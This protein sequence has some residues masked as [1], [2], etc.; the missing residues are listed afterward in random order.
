MLSDTETNQPRANV[1]EQNEQEL[2]ELRR[3]RNGNGD[4]AHVDHGSIDQPAAKVATKRPFY[5]RPIIASILGIV[6]LVALFVGTQLFLHAMAYESTDDAF[7]EG[8]VVQISTKSAGYA[9][10][11]AVNDN[12]HVKAG[13]LLVQVD[14]RD[15]QAKLDQQRAFVFMAQSKLAET[16]TNL[17]ALRANVKAAESEVASAQASYEHAKIEAEKFAKMDQSA[18]WEERHGA[19]T[20]ALTWQANVQTAQSKLAAAQ[21][22]VANGESQVKTAEAQVA[23]AQTMVRQ[24]ELDVSYTTI[25]APVDGRVTRK[26]VEPGA[27]LSVGQALLAVVPDDV[28]VVANFKETQLK[29]MR[30]GQKVDV[31]IDAYPDR[32]FEGHVDSIQSG[33][34]SRF[35][36]LPPENATGNYVKVVQRVPVKIV[37]DQAPPSDL[38]LAPGMSVEPEVL[39]K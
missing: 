21:A 29:Q 19:E 20:E 3:R 36:L 32:K 39:V 10:Q 11:V 6:A 17:E 7:I 22:Q 34:G 37:F 8:H 28:W 4:A 31:K 30:P 38:A 26:S 24:S 5:K 16:N 15:Y 12:Q 13:D 35:S 14:S 1:A 23:V 33:T 2:V 25:R 27:Y 9:Q 18:S